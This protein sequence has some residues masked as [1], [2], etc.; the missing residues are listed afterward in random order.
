MLYAV[1]TAT[2]AVGQA[3]AVPQPHAMPMGAEVIVGDVSISQNSATSMQIHNSPNAIINWQSFSI[4]SG[5]STQFIQQSQQ[6]AILNRV[7]GQDPSSILGN[8]QSNGKVFLINPNGVVFGAGAVV[9]TA[10]LVVSS[11][12][13]SNE[14]FIQGQYNF[15][16]NESGNAS[17]VNQGYIRSGKNGEVVLIAPQVTNEGVIE[18]DDGSILLAAG[19]SITLTSLD[20]EGISLKLSAPD[21]QVLNLGQLIADRGAVGLFA[22]VIHHSGTIQANSL[23]QGD[24]GQIHLVATSNVELAEES[25]TSAT[26]GNI[27]ISSM[28]DTQI[29]GTLNTDGSVQQDAGKI[30]VLGQQVKL[31]NA[32]IS[33][34]A[35]S[36]GGE[37]RI[38]GDFQGKGELTT[39]DNTT[40]DLAS[41]IQANGL[42]NGPGGSVIVWADN[43]TEMHGSISAVGGLQ[44]GDGGFVEV[45]G[46][47]QLQITGFVDLSANNGDY[48]ELLLDPESIHI[49]VDPSTADGEQNVITVDWIEQGLDAATVNIVTDSQDIVIDSPINFSSGNTLILDA[50]NNID[51]RHPITAS[52]HS[53]I[54]LNASGNVINSSGHEVVVTAENLNISSKKG[55]ALV[56]SLVFEAT[57]SIAV[58]AT[59]QLGLSAHMSANN[60]LLNSERGGVSQSPDS[61]ISSGNV[62]VSAKGD[63][64]LAGTS[65]SFNTISVNTSEAD[66]GGSVNITHDEN[67]N[68]LSFGITTPEGVDVNVEPYRAPIDSGITGPNVTDPGI[69]DT[70][71]TDSSIAGT[72]I[73]DGEASSTTGSSPT[74]IG[75]LPIDSGSSVS[76]SSTSGSDSSTSEISSNNDGSL[77]L[78]ADSDPVS[79]LLASAEVSKYKSDLEA[80]DNGY[81]KNNKRSRK[82]HQQQSKILHCSRI[83]R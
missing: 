65:N 43:R 58:N 64:M 20:A 40:I 34:S 2:I 71:I 11:L 36:G 55:L 35:N 32:Q 24:D 38:G 78:G 46:K 6:S 45:S 82:S 56:D 19:Q 60:I 30:T 4:Q 28:G 15:Q 27:F 77:V 42:E 31:Q 74:G 68:I 7:V 12:A 72:G 66:N 83:H 23:V 79:L 54:V 37:I 22:D 26:G 52:N 75:G 10:G 41:N 53:Q 16:A 61:S 73:P 80:E 25:H 1:I 67:I 57:D 48:G 49:V 21:D 81:Y 70:G 8:L 18:T 50:G 69:T 44:S 3:A 39:A 33:S 51:I 17:I 59:E 47:Y 29:S 13:L 62:A 14:D 5:E 76:S 63:V 9:D